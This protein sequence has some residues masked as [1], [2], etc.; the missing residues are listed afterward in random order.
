MGAPAQRKHIQKEK[1]KD[2]HEEDSDHAPGGE[3]D[4]ERVAELLWVAERR[5]DAT[6]WDEDRGV[7]HPEGAV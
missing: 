3:V 2:A 1:S 5:G 6:R 4:A 7:G